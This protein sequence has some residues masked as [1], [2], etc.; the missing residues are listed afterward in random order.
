MRKTFATLAAVMAVSMGL[1]VSATSALPLDNL[2]TLCDY[3]ATQTEAAYRQRASLYGLTRQ[4][5][6][7]LEQTHVC[8]SG[9]LLGEVR[10]R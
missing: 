10:K 3:R 9:E 4:Q 6:N 5:L 1:S 7:R 8:E 2:Q